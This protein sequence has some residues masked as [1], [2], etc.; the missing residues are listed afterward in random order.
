MKA[1]YRN[2][3]SLVWVAPAQ[4]QESAKYREHREYSGD[5]AD[6]HHERGAQVV[7]CKQFIAS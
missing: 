7:V 2:K 5:A 4:Q 1:K 6:E 3:F